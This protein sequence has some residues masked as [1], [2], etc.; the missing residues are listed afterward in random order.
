MLKN[1]LTVALRTLRRHKGYAFVNVAGLAV[2][3]AACVLIGLYVL[4]ELSYDRFHA[5]ADRIYRVTLEDYAASS[6]PIAPALERDYPHLVERAVRFWPIQAPATVRTG[7]EAFV[8]RRISFADPAVFDVFSYDLQAGDPERALAAPQ[9]MVVTASLARKYFGDEDAVGQTLQFWGEDY[10]VTGVMADLPANTH[11]PVDALVSFASLP[12]PPSMLENWTWAGFYTYVLLRD[13]ASPDRLS[14]ELASFVGRHTDEPLL[15]PELQPLP[16]IHLHS[17][18]RKEATPGGTVAVVYLL[19][20]IAVLLLAVACINFMNLSTARGAE[21]AREVGMR[22]ALGAQRRQLVGQFLGESVLMS[23]AALGVAL[24]LVQL[25]LPAFERLAGKPL[26]LAF[27]PHGEGAV[28]LL[29]LALV[30]GLAAGSYPALFLSRFQP[31]GILKR[32]GGAPASGLS[33]RRGLVVFQFAVSVALCIA[34]LVVYQQLGYLQNRG[35]G[36]DEEHV[37]VVEA[38]NY[39]VFEE[40]LHEAP[41]IVRVA[42]AYDVPGRRFQMLPVRTATMPT[43][44]TRAMRWLG[45]DYGFLETLGV[46]PAAGRLFSEDYATDVEHAVVVNEAAVRELGWTDAVG[47]RIDLYAFSGDGSTFEVATEGTVVGVVKDFN[48]ASLHGPVE[49]LLMTV[50]QGEA[51]NVAAVRIEPGQT[52]DALARIEAAWHTANPGDPFDYFFLDDQLDQQYRSEQQLSR[53]FGGFTALTVFI[54]CLGLFGLAAFTAQQRTKEIGVRKVLGASAGGIVLLLARDFVALVLLGVVV[55][56]PLAYLGMDRW[57]GGFAYRVDLG[58]G[59][60]VLA[61]GLALLVATATVAVQAFRAAATDPV[62][63]LRY[64]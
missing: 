2:G 40:A 10:E 57:L 55:A 38:G 42:A 13:D 48:Y 8:E 39:E 56:V 1:Y 32:R 7:G 35:L 50:A 15:P 47:E 51:V 37:V 16:S 3:M 11:Y 5:H 4:D 60:F 23:V 43:D 12:F 58:A 46:E 52:T 19:S 31:A 26:T 24:G 18:L 33:L 41:E 27:G 61:G 28:A 54:A 36:F 62:A 25:A 63:A 9:T 21:R 45:V 14:A 44:S 20:T 49:P 53:V 29:G 34:A 6:P 64:E 22:K 17:D 30:V 59:P